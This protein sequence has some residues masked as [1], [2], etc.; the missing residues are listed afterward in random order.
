MRQS[1]SSR[2]GVITEYAAPDPRTLNMQLLGLKSYDNLII[3]FFY[4]VALG[5]TQRAGRL[6]SSS[7]MESH[8]NEKGIRCLGQ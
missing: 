6:Q 3:A 1:I 2:T 5:V 8:K 4:F 7:R